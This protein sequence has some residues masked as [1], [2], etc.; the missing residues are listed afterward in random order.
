MD[1]CKWV[2]KRSGGWWNEYK[3]GCGKSFFTTLSVTDSGYTYCPHCGRKI[4]LE[5]E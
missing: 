5:E 4:E 3:T 1:K 2:L